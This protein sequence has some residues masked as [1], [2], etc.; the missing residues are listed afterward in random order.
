MIRT[1][2]I[3]ETNITLNNLNPGTLYSISVS[4]ING[5]GEGMKSSLIAANTP[6]V[7]PFLP[8]QCMCEHN[9]HLS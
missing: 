1:N 4:A 3:T 9:T 5:A 8:M 2:I 7:F 6:G